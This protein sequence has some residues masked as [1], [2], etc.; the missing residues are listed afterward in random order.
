MLADS[1]GCNGNGKIGKSLATV[2]DELIEIVC[3]IVNIEDGKVRDDV[4]DVLYSD[5]DDN[6]ICD[7]LNGIKTRIE[8]KY[9]I[10]YQ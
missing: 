1:F 2:A 3:L 4:I 8:K 9:S 6:E 10:K 7:M 5:K